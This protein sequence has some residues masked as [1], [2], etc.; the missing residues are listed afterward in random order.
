[1]SYD[2]YKMSRFVIKS[3]LRSVAAE[4]CFLRSETKDMFLKLAA[5]VW[6]EV[7]IIEDEAAE[8]RIRAFK[9][10]EERIRA[11]KLNNPEK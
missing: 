2:Y 6:D 1:M 5:E 9:A 10:A 7:Q 3:Q 4:A 11:F 8:E